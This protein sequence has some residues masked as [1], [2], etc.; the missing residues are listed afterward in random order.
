MGRSQVVVRDAVLED[1]D[2]LAGLW[3]TS[4]RRGESGVQRADLVAI[5]ERVDV[6]GTH[7]LVVAEH[8]ARPAGA[9]L[10]LVDTVSSLNLEPTIRVV[11]P[12][13]LPDVRRQGVGHALMEAALAFAEQHDIVTLST[14]VSPGAR[15]SNRFMARL[16][17]SAQATYR[18]ASVPVVRARLRGQRAGLTVAGGNGRAATRVIAARRSMRRSRAAG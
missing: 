5:L 2:F 6:L 10:L 13:V 9:V 17:F 8:D 4:L 11:S 15:E 14:A 12:I 7:R 18:L 1:L 3:S 16:G